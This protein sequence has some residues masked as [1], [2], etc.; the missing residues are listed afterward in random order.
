MAL[1]YYYYLYF[2]GKLN[3]S[4][5]S[6]ELGCNHNGDSMVMAA[7]RG[8]GAAQWQVMHTHNLVAL[9]QT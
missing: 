7:G 2:P 1:H 8:R 5:S 4:L 9:V 3:V 6:K